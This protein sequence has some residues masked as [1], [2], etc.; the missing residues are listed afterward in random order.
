MGTF[1]PPHPF[2]PVIQDMCLEQVTNLHLFVQDH[3]HFSR[4]G[5]SQKI[6]LVKITLSPCF[7]SG[8]ILV[9]YYFTLVEDQMQQVPLFIVHIMVIS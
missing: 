4:F 7:K 5:Q 3:Q 9:T 1:F 8:M 6:I 2:S